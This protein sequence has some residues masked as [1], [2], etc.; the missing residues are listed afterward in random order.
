[1][2]WIN[3][4]PILFACTDIAKEVVIM[5][6]LKENRFSVSDIHSDKPG[7]LIYNLS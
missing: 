7:S 4:H 3:K 6:F 1:M 5:D 2:V